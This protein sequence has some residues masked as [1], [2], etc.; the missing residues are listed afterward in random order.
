M[1]KII[2]ICMFSALVLIACDSQQSSQSTPAEQQPDAEARRSLRPDLLAERHQPQLLARQQV[3]GERR[4]LRR[5]R[6]APRP[7]PRA[8]PGDL[9]LLA[10]APCPPR[11]RSGRICPASGQGLPLFWAIGAP[12]AP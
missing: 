3:D 7:G 10:R 9:S 11:R 4:L 6:R 2:T 5:G 1:K 8:R 12:R